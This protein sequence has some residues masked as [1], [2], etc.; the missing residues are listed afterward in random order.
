MIEVA[1]DG[2]SQH[3]SF[4]VMNGQ[5]GG[6]AREEGGNIPS[7]GARLTWAAAPSFCLDVT[8]VME[9]RRCS[10]SK[11]SSR[12][13]RSEMAKWKESDVTMMFNPAPNGSMPHGSTAAAERLITSLL[14]TC[15][16]SHVDGT[17]DVNA[18]VELK[19]CTALQPCVC[20]QCK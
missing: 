1:T 3:R 10:T 6:K 18:T 14:A 5:R 7:A 2:G 9:G 19:D 13:K 11:G 12:D 17:T 16:S 4:T 15:C 8:E 20:V